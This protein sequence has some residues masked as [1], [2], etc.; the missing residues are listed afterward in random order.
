MW[1]KRAAAGGGVEAEEEAEAEA[2]ATR[3]ALQAWRRRRR[4]RWRQRGPVAAVEQKAVAA[5]LIAQAERERMQVEVTAKRRQMAVEAAEHRL[6]GEAAE[7]AAVGEEGAEPTALDQQK[8]WQAVMQKVKGAG[9]SEGTT[10]RTPRVE[11]EDE[12]SAS[13]PICASSGPSSV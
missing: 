11:E 8:R 3:A 10:R 6:R 1:P 13:D 4:W 7:A 2:A 12:A 9:R 5:N